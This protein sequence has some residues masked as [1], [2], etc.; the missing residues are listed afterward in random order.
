[1]KKNLIVSLTLLALIVTACGGQ[2][3]PTSPKPAA[4]TEAAPPVSTPTGNAAGAPTGNVSFAKDVKP[5][6]ENSC[7]GCHGVNQVKA[8]LDLR[9][10]ESLMAGSSNGPVIVTSKSTDSFLVQMVTEGK[11]PKRGSKLTSEQIK[12]ISDWINAGALNN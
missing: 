6:F 10:Y 12:T 1:M 4:P 9:T 7:I 8:G 5:I 2:T 3:T 11:M